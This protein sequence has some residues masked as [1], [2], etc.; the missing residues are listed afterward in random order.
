MER[1]R[2]S[3]SIRGSRVGVTDENLKAPLLTTQETF[4]SEAEVSVYSVAVAEPPPKL[5]GTDKIIAGLVT[6]LLVGG[7]ASSAAAMIAVHQIVVYVAG[8]FCILQV[9]VVADAQYKMAKQVGL[10]EA[11]NSLRQQ[12]HLLKEERQTLKETIN[13]L[14]Q[15]ANSLEGLEEDLNEICVKQGCNCDT[16]VSLVKENE[17]TL[18][19]M[20][21]YLRE[22]AMTDIARI[23]LLCDKN[24]D[25]KISEREL[26]DLV[27]ALK[28]RLEAHGIDLD[29]EKFRAMVR[30]DDD[31]GH[32]I[33]SLGKIMFDDEAEQLDQDRMSAVSSR[34]E[35][36]DLMSMF[37]IKDRYTRGSVDR[38]RGS[39]VHLSTRYEP[40]IRA[41]SGR[42]SSV[43]SREMS[44]K[45]SRR[46]TLTF[47]V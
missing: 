28:I 31:V 23:V 11:S 16:M 32:I 4:H 18:M 46:L 7:V 41:H 35:E 22:I 29:V 44:R 40:Y 6:L 42:H 10:R 5:S 37:V 30:K 9:P 17:Y 12:V 19:E 43:L 36:E 14:K 39:S 33:K 3:I 13:F 8:A 38:A 20:R 21:K 47:D 45:L 34:S 2:N 27:L 15:E 25:M 1:I 26:S 24:N